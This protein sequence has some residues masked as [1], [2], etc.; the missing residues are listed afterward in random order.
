MTDHL[1]PDAASALASGGFT[2][3][4]FLKGSGVLLVAFTMGDFAIVAEDAWAQGINGPGARTLDSW[5]A[6]GS[7]GMVTA[8]TGKC[9]LGQ[10]LYT[11]QVQLIAEELCVGVGRVHLVQCDTSITPDQGT[12]SGAQSHPANFNHANLA[13]AGATAR[14]ALQQL[15]A[16]RLGLPADQVQAR[17]GA[18]CASADPTKRATYGDLIGDRQFKIP[19]STDRQAKAPEGL[20]RA[21]QTRAPRRPARAGHRAREL[22]PQRASPRHAARARRPSARLRCNAGGGR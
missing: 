16:E 10:G 7:D 4:E 5:I 13:Q 22:R 12:T 20:G 19:V 17:D 3:R 9:E 8:Y 1:T 18:V 15:G 2:R 11:A 21:R 14:E 6:I